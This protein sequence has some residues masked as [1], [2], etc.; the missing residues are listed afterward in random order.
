MEGRMFY[1]LVCI[2]ESN[3]LE[4]RVLDDI[5]RGNLEEIHEYVKKNIDKYKNA[6]WMLL[7]FST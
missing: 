1:K 2:D 7:P 3:P 4:Y 6:K 5:N